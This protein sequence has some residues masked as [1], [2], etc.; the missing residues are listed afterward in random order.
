MRLRRLILAGLLSGLIPGLVTCLLIVSC[1]R[2]PE[3]LPIAPVLADA[4]GAAAEQVRV[5]VAAAVAP[6]IV[7]AREV[8]DTIVPPAPVP[9]AS[10][11]VH[12]DAVA[13]LIRYEVT[14]PEWYARRL[15]GVICPGLQS[16]PTWGIGYDGGHQTRAEIAADWHEHPDVLRLVEAAGRIGATECRG[17][18]AYVADVRTPFSA[19]QKVFAASTLP[20]YRALTARTFRA[21]WAGLHPLAQGVLVTI[22]YNRGAGMAGE[23]RREMRALRDTCVPAADYEC[24]RREI[25]AMPR[26]WVGTEIEVGLRNRYAA[27]AALL[28]RIS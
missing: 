21:G 16:G 22:I 24:M 3:P 26:H 1:T 11:E 25:L 9:A 8:V 14:S 17:W 10:D 6:T 4:P 28:N 19:A 18:L 13:L 2:A 20:K 27:T 7:A 12:P 5:E 23:R 15:Q